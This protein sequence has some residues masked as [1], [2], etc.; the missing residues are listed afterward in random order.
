MVLPGFSSYSRDSKNFYGT[1]VDPESWESAFSPLAHGKG[2]CD[3]L[4]ASVKSTAIRSIITSSISISSAEEYYHFTVQF[5]DNAA[6]ACKSNQP[7]IHAF[8]INSATV[9]NVYN[10]VLKPR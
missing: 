3:G 4:S 2:P 5:N 10:N 6:K 1:S 7:P 9:D 8:Y